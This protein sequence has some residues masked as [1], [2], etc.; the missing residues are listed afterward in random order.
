MYDIYILNAT[1][2]SD[3]DF[4]CQIDTYTH[5]VTPVEF[6]FNKDK[7]YLVLPQISTFAKDVY[8]GNS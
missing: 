1:D 7:T 6:S 3:T 8:Y 5:N 2:L 4:A